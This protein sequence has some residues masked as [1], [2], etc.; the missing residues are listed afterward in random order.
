[1]KP[2]YTM[3][4]IALLLRVLRSISGGRAGDGGL[5]MDTVDGSHLPDVL[6]A[7][8]DC[9][10]SD[11]YRHEPVRDL[12]SNLDQLAADDTITKCSG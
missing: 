5:R 11:V 3:R 2:Q 7:P 12:E 6:M 4:W 10:R 1:M 8:N 9:G